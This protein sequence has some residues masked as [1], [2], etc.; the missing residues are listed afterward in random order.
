MFAR[1]AATRFVCETRDSKVGVSCLA[2]TQ[3][4]IPQLFECHG[5]SKDHSQNPISGQPVWSRKITRSNP[6]VGREAWAHNRWLAGSHRV[7][8]RG[9][10]PHIGAFNPDHTLVQEANMGVC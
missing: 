8:V 10:E 6:S 9:V 4:K 1:R 2:W 7:M 5:V 3:G